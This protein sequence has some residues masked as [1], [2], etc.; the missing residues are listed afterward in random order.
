MRKG[1]DEVGKRP[2]GDFHNYLEQVW[3]FA[4]SPEP[5][6]AFQQDVQKEVRLRCGAAK[7]L[8]SQLW[9]FRFYERQLNMVVTFRNVLRR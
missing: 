3:D 9:V 4:S 5:L 6:E 8:P 1:A 2:F 7:R